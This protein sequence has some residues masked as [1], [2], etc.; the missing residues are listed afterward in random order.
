[1]N[2]RTIKI[3]TVTAVSPEVGAVRVSFFDEDNAVS[4]LLP[5]IMPPGVIQMPKVKESVIC[6]FLSSSRNEGF[7]LGGTY[8]IQGEKLPVGSSSAV[9]VSKVSGT[10][11]SVPYP[12]GWK[13]EETFIIGMKGTINGQLQQISN[14][15]AVYTGS[16]IDIELSN[17]TLTSVMLG[18]AVA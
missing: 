18:R 1:M 8:Y 5:V 2:Q 9:H 4:Y 6:V 17:G 10:T 16:G 13:V 15:K 12:N 11:A 14:Y 7:C 3:G